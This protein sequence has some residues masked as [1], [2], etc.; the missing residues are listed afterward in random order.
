LEHRGGNWAGLQ[1]PRPVLFVPNVTAHPSTVSAPIT[2][3]LYNGRL[4][5]G[6]NVPQPAS[7]YFKSLCCL[8]SVFFAGNTYCQPAFTQTDNVSGFTPLNSPGVSTLQWSAGRGL[9]CLTSLVLHAR[10]C[11]FAV[12]KRSLCRCALSVRSSVCPS[13]SCILSKQGNMFS[14]FF[15]RWVATPF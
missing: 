11:F 15:H 7:H 9:L 6:F 4:L 10:N 14:N 2:V 5:C 13:R 8:S 12:H 3:L 1:P